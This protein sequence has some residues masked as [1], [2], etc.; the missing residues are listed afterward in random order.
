V[1]AGSEPLAARMRSEGYSTLDEFEAHYPGSEEPIGWLNYVW[2]QCRWQRLAAQMFDADGESALARFWE[3]F[4]VADRTYPTPLTAV[5]LAPI[6][7]DEVSQTLGRA[8]RDW[9]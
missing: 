2:F 3:C 1:G 8:V 7:A 9:R 5:S 4:H 6:L